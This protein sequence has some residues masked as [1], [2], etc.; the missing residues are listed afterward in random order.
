LRNL[1]PAA[2]DDLAAVERA[3]EAGYPKIEPILSEL[4]V[5]LQDGNWP[6]FSAL[7]PFLA[8]IG[9][10]IVAEV[11]RI[12]ATDD[13]LWKYWVIWE[14]SAESPVELIRALHE[15]LLRV[16]NSPTPGESEEGVDEAARAALARLGESTNA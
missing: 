11:R 2:K 15:D 7:A 16:A 3:V 6:I 4:F 9:L 8:R 5:W 12:L 10:P 13:D 1:V 14:V